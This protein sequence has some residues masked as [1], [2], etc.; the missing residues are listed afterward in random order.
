MRG[1]QWS[2][3][4]ACLALLATSPASA[5]EIAPGDLLMPCAVWGVTRIEPDTGEQ[6][7]LGINGNGAQLEVDA[8][9]LVWAIDNRRVFSIERAS[10]RAA[11]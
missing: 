10:I 2:W 3:V 6:K 4:G 7:P 11:A 9:G 8:A 5:R 1:A